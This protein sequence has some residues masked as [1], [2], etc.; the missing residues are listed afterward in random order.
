MPGQQSWRLGGRDAH[1]RTNSD[2][3]GVIGA[4]WRKRPSGFV[5]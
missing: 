2:L 1:Y 4:G 3:W 5:Q